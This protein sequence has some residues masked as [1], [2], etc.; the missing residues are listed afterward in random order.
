MSSLITKF[1]LSFQINL[2]LKNNE[3]HLINNSKINKKLSLHKYH[4]FSL[5]TESNIC[6]TIRLARPR[7]NLHL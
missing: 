7:K 3:G 5:K 1:L 4:T 2:S 6:L